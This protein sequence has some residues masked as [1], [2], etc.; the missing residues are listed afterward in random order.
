MT[1]MTFDGRAFQRAFGHQPML[2]AHDLW[3]EPLLALTAIGS[4]ATEL[5]PED[6]HHH[7]G[8]LPKLM[9]DGDPPRLEATPAEIAHSIET[10]NCRL[11]L[12]F[13]QQVPRYCELMNLVLD[14]VEPL[15]GDREGGMQRRESFLFVSA[16]SVVVP[17]HA[18]PE[19]N[20]L[21]QVRGTKKVRVGNFDDPSVF[22]ADLERQYL[23]GRGYL[24]TMPDSFTDFVL[25][26]GDGLYLPPHAPHLVENADETCIAFSVTFYT[27]ATDRVRVLYRFNG[28]V[29]KLGLSPHR[30]G[31]IARLDRAKLAAI[32]TWTRAKRLARRIRGD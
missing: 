1:T 19:H 4:L 11:S 7:L 3:A 5:A 28:Y 20:F 29:R 12:R 17:L 23:G 32:K 10:N 25:K 26:P 22:D 8:D 24:R 27:P 14:R 15:V 2:V 6:V 16:P 18:D 9:L 21:L 30:P 31:E 13:I